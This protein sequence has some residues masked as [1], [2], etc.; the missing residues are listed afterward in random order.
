MKDEK[1]DFDNVKAYIEYLDN[2]VG[3]SW[4]NDTEAITEVM[5]D[6]AKMKNEKLLK[7]I[8]QMESLLK[9]MVE[10]GGL[11]AYHEVRAEEFLNNEKID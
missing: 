3:E 4:S 10:Q 5:E 7:K 2:Q 1:L 11:D 9:E 8:E 6:F